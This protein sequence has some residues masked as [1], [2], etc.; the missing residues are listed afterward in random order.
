MTARKKRAKRPETLVRYDDLWSYA[1]LGS[2]EKTTKRKILSQKIQPIRI[3]KAMRAS[4]LVEQMGR[5]SIQARNLGACAGV[6]GRMYT[7]RAR[8]TVMLGLAGPLI[9]AGLRR[10]IRDLVVGGYVDVVVSTGAIMYQDIYQ[11]KG[12]GHYI[13][14]PAANDKQL[15]DLRIDRIYDTYVDEEKF[16]DTDTWCGRIADQLTPGNYSSRAF[17]DF[18]GAKLDDPES[19]LYQCHKL[20]VPV[21]CPALNDSSIGIGLTE[22]Y[23]RCRR[24]NRPGIT[25]DAIRDNYELAQIVVKSPKTAAI[26]VAGGV[27]KNYI[28]DSIVMSYIWGQER[29]HDYA[30]QVTTAV[31]Q[32]GGLSGSTLGE[33]QSWGKIRKEAHFAM[34]WVEPSVSLPLLAAY[35]FDKHPAPGRGRLVMDWDGEKLKSIRRKASR[36][37]PKR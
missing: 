26:Y 36:G 35:I 1:P 11:A 15:R 13:G 27:P 29:G 21:F 19:I 14:T 10:V 2:R 22:H 4:D 32:D 12:F 18:L 34:A 20:G 30:V 33:A 5:M 3:R 25:I 6:L 28:N 31:T 16:W 17:L 7:D 23:F 9:A 8:P 37:R 24:D